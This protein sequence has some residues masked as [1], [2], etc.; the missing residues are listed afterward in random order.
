M[1][2]RIPSGRHQRVATAGCGADL[3]DS[4]V[5]EQRIPFA[6]IQPANRII[7]DGEIF[8]IVCIES[9]GTRCRITIINNRGIRRVKVGGADLERAAVRIKTSN[10]RA[11][12]PL[13]FLISA[14]TSAASSIETAA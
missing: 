13:R 3:E 1:D 4:I 7:A 11:E 8:E 9:L 6:R 5:F 2:I 10:A 14:N 12:T